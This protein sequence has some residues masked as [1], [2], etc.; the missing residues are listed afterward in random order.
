MQQIRWPTFDTFLFSAQNI[1]AFKNRIALYGKHYF[2]TFLVKL[3]GTVGLCF[4]GPYLGSITLVI[5][6]NKSHISEASC[7]VYTWILPL[8]FSVTASEIALLLFFFFFFYSCLMAAGVFVS[9]HAAVSVIGS[10]VPSDLKWK[11]WQAVVKG[12]CTSFYQANYSC[13]KVDCGCSHFLHN[14]F[15]CWLCVVTAYFLCESQAGVGCS[16]WV[17]RV[18][19]FLCGS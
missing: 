6:P 10:A 9:N 19:A 8:S 14:V 7:A 13:V 15:S 18:T 2:S 1:K 17:T 11:V 5:L 12:H 4:K 3:N 16:V